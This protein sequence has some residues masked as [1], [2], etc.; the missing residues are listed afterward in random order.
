[1]Q[2]NVCLFCVQ[3]EFQ[4]QSFLF[5]EYFVVVVAVKNVTLNTKVSGKAKPSNLTPWA[6]HSSMTPK[7]KWSRFEK[8]KYSSKLPFSTCSDPRPRHF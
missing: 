1:M 5:Y 6:P 7:E 8:R 3:Q 4:M 2:R